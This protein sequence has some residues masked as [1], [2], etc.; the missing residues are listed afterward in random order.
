MKNRLRSLLLFWVT[1]IWWKIMTTRQRRWR[2]YV[3]LRVLA[4][5]ILVCI[6]KKLRTKA[7]L[8]FFFVCNDVTMCLIIDFCFVLR[9]LNLFFASF[10]FGCLKFVTRERRKSVRHSFGMGSFLKYRRARSAKRSEN[11]TILLEKEANKKD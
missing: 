11:V 5:F 4:N 7:N 2:A 10:M 6:F 3:W 9:M 1:L 8:S